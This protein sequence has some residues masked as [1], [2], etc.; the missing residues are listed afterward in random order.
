MHVSV[1]MCYGVC[2]SQKTIIDWELVLPSHYVALLRDQP[3]VIS[4]GVECFTQRAILPTCK[5]L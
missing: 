2:G 3:W 5:N 4:L 1:C